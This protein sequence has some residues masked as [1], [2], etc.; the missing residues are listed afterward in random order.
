MSTE[1]GAPAPCARALGCHD[2]INGTAA[3]PAPTAPTT[4]VVAVRNRRRPLL[5][6]GLAIKALQDSIGKMGAD[7]NPG[8]MAA[9]AAYRAKFTG[10]TEP[11]TTHRFTMPR[12]EEHTSELQSLMRISYAV[13]CL[14]KKNSK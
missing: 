12:S 7:E 13:F 3:K 5:T 11:A 8:S 10:S 6:S 2:L 1:T 4:A 9:S 14:K